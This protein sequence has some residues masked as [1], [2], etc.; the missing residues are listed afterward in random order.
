MARGRF[1]ARRSSSYTSCV[2]LSESR[3][4]VGL[5]ELRLPVR[6]TGQRLLSRRCPAQ[7]LQKAAELE[8][9]LD[10]RRRA[11]LEAEDLSALQGERVGRHQG[12]QRRGVDELRFREVRDDKLVLVEEAFHELQDGGRRGDVVLAGEGEYDRS[13]AR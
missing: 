13:V 7:T 3:S 4:M 11:K 1:Q 2:A 9:P 8:C 12:S 6:P 10:D 5:R